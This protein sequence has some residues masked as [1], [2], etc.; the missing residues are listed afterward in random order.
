LSEG[1]SDGALV[2]MISA[3]EEK[4]NGYAAIESA[5]VAAEER[6]LELAKHVWGNRR[7]VF[8]WLLAG[9]IL[10]VVISVFIPNQYQSTVQLMP[11]DS[12]S[13]SGM[14]AALMAGGGPGALS[15]IG[16]LMGTRTNGAVFVAVLHSRTVADHLVD[17]F[18]LMKRY[19]TRRL[20]DARKKL[21]ERTSIS[22][23]RKSGVIKLQVVDEDRSRAQALT[24]GYVEELNRAVIDLNTS[25]AHR[26]RVFLEERLNVVRTQ[27]QQ[28]ENRLGEFSSK[29]GAID[30]KEQA[31]AMFTS[32]ATL[33]GQLIAAQS[34]LQGLRQIYGDSN[35]RVRAAN[36][37]VDELNRAMKQLGG[38]NDKPSDSFKPSSSEPYPSLRQL[39]L[40][41]SSFADYYRDAKVQE[42]VFETLTKQ[43]ELARVQEAKETPAVKILDAANMPERK[44]FPPRT[45]IAL[46][47][48][49]LGL[50]AGLLKTVSGYWWVNAD[51]ATKRVVA[52]LAGDTKSDIAILLA[53]VRRVFD[54]REPP[55][56]A[57]GD[58]A[59]LPITNR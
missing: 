1:V 26:E 6:S 2:N 55:G 30:I 50:C 53:A 44:S 14:L 52:K 33:Q 3:E 35:P 36:A 13:N 41:G 31:H 37:K 5:A 21:D 45:I 56:T 51:G 24:N 17:R 42:V 11:P 39:P 48:A 46:A 47:G 10:A 16:N 15:D 23:D 9:L 27:L 22:E 19:R 28:A 18:Q 20:E 7:L 32:A 12:N 49:W 38:L 43:Y 25:A 54:K 34:E 58:D 57:V 4:A 59:H 40:L 29:N 8:R